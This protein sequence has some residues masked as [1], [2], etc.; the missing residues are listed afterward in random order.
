MNFRYHQG[1]GKESIS[2]LEHF[3]RIMA[4]YHLSSGSLSPSGIYLVIIY[5]YRRTCKFGLASH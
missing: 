4:I 3:L 5:A 1:E 2:W